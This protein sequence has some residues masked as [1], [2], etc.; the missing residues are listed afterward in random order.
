MSFERVF[1][2]IKGTVLKERELH[3]G[4]PYDHGS[5][6]CLF[7]FFWS[8]THRGPYVVIPQVAR[9]WLL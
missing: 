7:D 9:L 4:K 2:Q 3:T 1:K 6:C 5:H 8:V